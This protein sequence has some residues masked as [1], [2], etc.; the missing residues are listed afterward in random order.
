MNS[1]DC[2]GKPSGAPARSPMDREIV[3]S[4]KGG[5]CKSLL[6]GGGVATAAPDVRR[7]SAAKARGI[8][9]EAFANFSSGP[10]IVED[11]VTHVYF[12]GGAVNAYKSN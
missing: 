9:H 11:Y 5:F 10:L 6:S 3:S 4:M 7:S 8:R 2:T 12:T 1:I